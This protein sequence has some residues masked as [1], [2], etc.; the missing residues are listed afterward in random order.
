MI[1]E[2]IVIR[3][4]LPQDAPAIADAH[5]AAILTRAGSHYSVEQLVAW[6]GEE[7]TE[8]KQSKIKRIA[9]E[10]INPNFI[11]YVAL[12]DGKV[13]GTSIVVPAQNELRAVYV[14][15][16][17]WCGVGSALLEKVEAEAYRQGVTHLVCDSSLNAENFYLRHGYKISEYTNHLLLNGVE[18]PCVRMIKHW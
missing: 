1:D 4:T 10:A 13:I 14:I 6:V 7:K 12:Y 17:I 9:A 3:R 5:R 16:G 8:D 18:I 2:T 11:S 15:R